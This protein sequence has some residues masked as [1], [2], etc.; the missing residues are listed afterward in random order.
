MPVEHSSCPAMLYYL[1]FF[2]TPKLTNGNLVTTLTVV[3]DLGDLYFYGT[4]TIKVQLIKGSK[5]IANQLLHWS[6]GNQAVKSCLDLSK[7]KPQLLKTAFLRVSVDGIAQEMLYDEEPAFVDLKSDL[8]SSASVSQYA[9]RSL[10]GLDFYEEAGTHNLARHLWDAGMYVAETL[11]TGTLF[12]GAA[13]STS[14]E[15]S[16]LTQIIELGTGCGIVGITVAKKSGLGL[17]NIFLTDTD[18][19]RALCEKNISEN[20]AK[21]QFVEYQWGLPVTFTTADSGTL[22]LVTDCTYNPDSYEALLR[23]IM[24]MTGAYL[25]LGHKYRNS[26]EESFFT[27]LP[28][29]ATVEMDHLRDYQGQKI[30]I[31]GARIH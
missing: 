5:V 18:D 9:I 13:A 23:A 10:F 16:N 31:I 17:N 8:M 1:R 20:S 25:L 14:L 29:I 21:A 27:Q 30:R 24:K 6:P 11:V 26:D 4:A 12:N 22:V 3:N 28:G 2:K 7:I 19:A 15:W